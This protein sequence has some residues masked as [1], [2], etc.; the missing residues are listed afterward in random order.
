MKLFLKILFKRI[1]KI[2]KVVSAP[3]SARPSPLLPLSFSAPSVAAGDSRV[4]STAATTLP[5]ALR[6]QHPCSSPPES[7][8]PP[9]HLVGVA[10]VPVDAPADPATTTAC[11]S[12][13]PPTT[14]ADLHLWTARVEG[15]L[16]LYSRFL[17]TYPPPFRFS[18]DEFNA[19][20]NV[21]L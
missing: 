5:V 1:N 21:D 14:S 7:C 6:R 18:Y 15:M 20:E 13:P 10:R 16:F 3:P 17:L 11:R 2:K 8:L 9:R 12:S 19:F 4:S